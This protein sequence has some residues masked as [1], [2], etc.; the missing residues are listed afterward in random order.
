MELMG[1]EDMTLH[2]TTETWDFTALEW[3]DPNSSDKSPEL[4]NE[5][6]CSHWV[7]LNNVGCKKYEMFHKA[8]QL[9]FRYMGLSLLNK[10]CN[11]PVWRPSCLVTAS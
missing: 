1:T 9:E 2:T 7:Y 10:I 8:I 5:Y 4:C 11:R 3:F 6:C